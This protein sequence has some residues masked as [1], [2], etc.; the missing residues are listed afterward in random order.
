M[1]SSLF[2]QR[3]CYGYRSFSSLLNYGRNPLLLAIRIDW[4]FQF[5]QSGWGKLHSI[6]KVTAFFTSLNLPQ[7]H[8]TAILVA[9]VEFFGG[10][11]FALGL[12]SRLVSLVLFVNMTVAYITAD[13]EALSHFFNAPDKFA[14]ADPFTFWFAALIV[15]IFGPGAWALDTL[16]ARSFCGTP[17]NS[18]SLHSSS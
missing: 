6:D 3:L 9:S 5:A 13:K 4:G 1:P 2:V 12:G 17:P 18:R 10:I 14:A 11:L 8:L 15:L 7:P 16:I